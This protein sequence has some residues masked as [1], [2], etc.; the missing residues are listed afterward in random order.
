MTSSYKIRVMVVDDH[1][2]VRDGLKMFL[3]V[4]DDMEF[5]G[6]AGDGEAAVELCSQMTPDVVLMD[7]VMPRM[8]GSAATAI[9]RESFPE[10]QVIALTSYAEENLVHQ[11]LEAGAIGYVLKDIESEKL[12]VA[13]R[14]AYQGQVTLDPVVAKILVQSASQKSKLGDD[15]TDRELEVLG[16]IVEGRTNQE[17]AEELTI[18]IGTVR[19]HVSNILSKLGARNRT[20][21]ARLAGKHGLVT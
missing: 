16:L 19:F 1:Q 3:S 7:L 13:I 10:V 6:E 9:I 17:I 18:S 5:I 15:L 11:A 12:A 2:V 20:E 8:D 4:Q 14:E 21:A